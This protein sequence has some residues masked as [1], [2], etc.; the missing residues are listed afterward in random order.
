M[1]WYDGEWHRDDF[2][3]NIMLPLV[4]GFSVGVTLIIV[5]ITSA[6]VYKFRFELRLLQ[7]KC[8][9]CVFC[10]CQ[11]CRRHQ[12]GNVKR[13]HAFIIYHNEQQNYVKENIFKPLTTCQ[14]IC[15]IG[16]DFQN[17]MPSGNIL[18]FIEEA[19]PNSHRVIMVLNQAFLDS[20]WGQYELDQGLM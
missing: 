17:L 12:P 15:N 7:N 2:A 6:I 8:C 1:C 10:F 20:E 11:C 14:G 9:P 18:R 4:I 3:C 13:H 16:I 19:I 5:C